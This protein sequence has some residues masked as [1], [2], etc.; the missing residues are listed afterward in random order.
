MDQAPHKLTP[1][2]TVV[3][4][5]TKD[6]AVLLEMTTGDCFELNQVGAEIWSAL[7]TGQPLDDIVVALTRR[8]ELPPSAI[9]TDVRTLIEDLLGKGLLQ[10]R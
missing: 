8:Y 5:P 2:P 10:S 9:E 7:A 1:N 4:Q 3:S 6:G